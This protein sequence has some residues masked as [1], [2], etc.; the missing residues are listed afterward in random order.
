MT[1]RVRVWLETAVTGRLDHNKKLKKQ[2][3]AEQ[4][5]AK[6]A[7]PIQATPK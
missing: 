3:E 7:T 5:Q 4:Q 1:P 6:S 2:M